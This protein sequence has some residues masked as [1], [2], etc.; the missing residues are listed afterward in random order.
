ML[1]GMATTPSSR[2]PVMPDRARSWSP[3]TGHWWLGF[4][5]WAPTPVGHAGCGNVSS[6][7][8]RASG[9]PPRRRTERRR[10]S[11]GGSAVR[12]E[13][14]SPA[15]SSNRASPATLTT[16]RTMAREK[17]SP[18]A[19]HALYGLLSRMTAMPDTGAEGRKHPC[20]PWVAPKRPPRADPRRRSVHGTV[21]RPDRRP[22]GPTVRWLHGPASPASANESRRSPSQSARGSQPSRLPRGQ[23]TPRPTAGARPMAAA[24]RREGWLRLRRTPAADAAAGRPTA[25]PHTAPGRH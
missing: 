15:A 23:G 6:G 13:R 8:P 24:G 25:W 17:T 14:R 18:A 12:A 19:H 10:R 11:G 16:H 2:R 9:T 1:P 22:L 3:R 21:P 4:G 20:A 7:G 5:L